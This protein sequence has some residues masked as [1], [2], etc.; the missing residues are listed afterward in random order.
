MQV[1]GHLPKVTHCVAVL[2]V[3]CHIFRVPVA[4]LALFE[5]KLFT[6]K[7]WTPVYTRLPDEATS[8]KAEKQT[9]CGR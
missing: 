8:R 5:G 3:L 2:Q 9:S 6:L 7:D 1:Q 4:R